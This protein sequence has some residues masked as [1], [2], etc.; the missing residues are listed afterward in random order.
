LGGPQR[1]SGGFGEKKILDP[2]GARTPDLI[3]K[4][5]NGIGGKYENVT[6]GINS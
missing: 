2:T 3:A 4:K 6:D 5:I 1:S